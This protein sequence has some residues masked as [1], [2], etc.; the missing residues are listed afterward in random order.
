[1]ALNPHLC[2]DK[3]LLSWLNRVLVSEYKRIEHLKNGAAYCQLMDMLFPQSL[4]NLRDVFFS[5]TC[6]RESRKN[7]KLFSKALEKMDI[8][9][10]LPVL[11]LIRGSHSKNLQMLKWFKSVYDLN[12]TGRNYDVLEE[13]NGC[14]MGYIEKEKLESAST[15]QIAPPKCTVPKAKISSIK[16]V[17]HEPDNLTTAEKV[18]LLKAKAQKAREELKRMEATRDYYIRKLKY[19]EQLCNLFESPSQ[20]RQLIEAVKKTLAEIVMAANLDATD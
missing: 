5:T 17:S 3:Q 4:I 15:Q 14:R 16:D 11:E 10:E 18:V 13:R 12:Y 6:P 19:V 20:Q 2:E 7:L 1:M 9:R 8:K